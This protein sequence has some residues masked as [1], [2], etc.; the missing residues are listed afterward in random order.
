MAQRGVQINGVVSS[1]LSARRRA[2]NCCPGAWGAVSGAYAG[3]EERSFG[4]LEGEAATPE[5]VAASRTD[6]A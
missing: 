1:R 3:L 6:G 4:D 2:G 5:L